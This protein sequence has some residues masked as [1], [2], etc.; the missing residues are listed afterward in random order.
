MKPEV[1]EQLAEKVLT[2]EQVAAFFSVSV[3]TL[4]EQP[5]FAELRKEKCRRGLST[6]Y[7]TSDVLSFLERSKVPTQAKPRGRRRVLEIARG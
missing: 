6:L 7:L 1:P 2:E 5:S 4:R 3:R